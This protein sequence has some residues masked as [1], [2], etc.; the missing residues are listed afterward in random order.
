VYS[1]FRLPTRQTA[2]FRVLCHL[3]TP[4]RYYMLNGQLT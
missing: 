1:P 4:V 2:P 3:H